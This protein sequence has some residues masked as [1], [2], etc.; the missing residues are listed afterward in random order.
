[1]ILDNYCDD[2]EAATYELFVV[3]DEMWCQ[4]TSNE[5]VGQKDIKKESKNL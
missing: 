5:T 2:S 1:M 4:W 3:Y